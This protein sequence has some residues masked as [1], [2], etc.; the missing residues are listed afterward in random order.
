MAGRGGAAAADD[1]LD[2]AAHGLEGDAERLEGLGRHA[3]ALVDQPEQDV[4]GPDVGVAEL[5]GLLAGEDD[6]P[7]SSVSES[8]EHNGSVPGGCGS[9]PQTTHTAEDARTSRWNG[10]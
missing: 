1:L 3:L 6:D 2:L 5:A 9:H 10:S 7:T 4:L 8:L